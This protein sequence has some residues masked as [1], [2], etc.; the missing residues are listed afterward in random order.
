MKQKPKLTQREVKLISFTL[1][2]LEMGRKIQNGWEFLSEEK[3]VLGKQYDIANPGSMK[4]KN[5]REMTEFI[6][7]HHSR[8]QKL[9]HEA[10]QLGIEAHL[11]IS[12]I[13]DSMRKHCDRIEKGIFLSYSSAKDMKRVVL[14]KLAEEN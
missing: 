8:C 4:N 10:E 11:E 14:R 13:I 2:V 6:H 12:S 1:E 9:L 7:G 3:D 5:D